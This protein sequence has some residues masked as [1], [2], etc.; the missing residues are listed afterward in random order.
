MWR[1][2]VKGALGHRAR[3][4]I[5]GLVVTFSVAFVVATLVFTDTLS[6]SFESIFEDSFAGFD[7]QVRS[8]IDDD[9]S[10]SIPDPV[11]A[12]ILDV[13]RGVKGVEQAQG[14]VTG[15]L[16]LEGPDGEPIESAG[17]PIL[18]LTWP[19]VPSIAEIRTGIPPT[20]LG[21]VAVDAA[22]A[23][24][25]NI[26]VG[27]RLVVVGLGAPTEVEVSGIVTFAESPSAGGVITVFSTVEL[28]QQ[29]FGLEG[30]YSTLEVVAGEDTALVAQR[31]E[32]VLGPGFEAI[33]ADDLARQQVEGFQDAIGFIR[34]FVLVFAGVALF[35]G[36]FVISN[37]FRVTIAQ[38]TR[39]LAVLRAI[40]ATAG[41]IRNLMLAEAAVISVLASA[42]GAV[43]GVGLA[44]L[45]RTAF[46]AA[47]I[48]LPPGPLQVSS[49]AIALGLATGIAVTAAAAVIPA[50]KAARVSPIEAMREGFAPPGRRALRGRLR[51]GGPLAGLGAVSMLLGLFA[52][53]PF[54]DDLWLVGA[55]AVMLF[56]GVAVL[57]AVIARP[58]AGVLGRPAAATGAVAG[59]L[60]REN[61]MR[62]P[63][64]TGLTASALMISLALV[65]LVAILADSART[66]ADALIEDRFRADLIVAPTGFSSLGVSPEV[67]A[68]IDAL[69]E[70]GAVG[71]VR[72]GEVLLGERSRVVGGVTPEVFDLLSFQVTEGVLEDLGPGRIAV[73]ADDDTPAIGETI[74]VTAPVGGDRQLEVVAI[75][76]SNPNAFLVSMVAFED[77]FS[78]RLDSQVLVR[79][80]PG[81]DVDA[82]FAAVEAAVADFPSIQLQDQD[83]FR[84]EATGQI[85]GIVNLL[86]ALLAVSVVIGTLGVVGTLL[87]SVVERTREIGLLR[88]I[89]MN[90]RQVRRMI[91]WEAVVIAVFGGVLG[92]V[93]GI[94]FGVAVVYAIG[95]ELRLSLPAG[96]LVWWLLVA[97]ALGI[98]AATYPARR[99]SRLDILEAV[100]YE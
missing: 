50:L 29:L 22:T 7:I 95:D 72:Q 99:A 76:E 94:L 86:Y 87:L 77:M 4:V 8:E 83:G 84:D 96:Q 45:I 89:G 20:G 85:G 39:E 48:P 66:T 25:E 30:R 3:L 98:L 92:T 21:Q 23:T 56:V 14:S 49:N 65:G 64:R 6:S 40:G 61:A 93:I 9:L 11:D 97:A 31:I 67:A 5:S 24:K 52:D 71:R 81:V 47:A 32:D 18:S 44:S 1:A 74:T 43:G 35:V 2:A 42:I 75:Y 100:A 51:V 54:V 62:S 15:F 91:R 57:A 78:E 26:E 82:G 46:D 53:L 34:T 10:F 60:A 41:Q 59:V 68:A 79:F 19:E 80:A 58:V 73:R 38:R 70:V 90:R 17:P 36:T 33:G 27:D 69:D 16:S 12:S 55:G 13:V 88:A 63:R 28:G 37:I